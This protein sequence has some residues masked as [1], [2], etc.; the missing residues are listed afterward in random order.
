MSTPGF[1]LL[2]KTD[3]PART[4]KTQNA[5]DLDKFIF[6]GLHHCIRIGTASDRYS[7]WGGQIYTPEK[8]VGRITKRSNNVGGKRYTEEI[9]PVDSVTEYF[10]HFDILEIDFTFYR[11]LLDKDLKPTSNYKILQAYNKYLNDS[12]RLILKVPQVIFARKLFKTGKHIDN[13]N[14]LNAEMFINQFYDPANA[15]LGDNLAGFIF[16]QEYQRK[17]DRVPP[18]KYVKDLDKFIGSLPKD[19]RYH[20]ETRTEFYLTKP[21]FE[22]LKKYGVGQ[23]L[24]H[25]AWLPRLLKQFAYAG[26]TFTNPESSIVRLITPIGMR[27][28]EAYALAFPFDM[29]IRGMMQDEM[30][31][32]TVSLMKTAVEKAITINVIINNRAG[33]SAPMLAREIVNNFMS[34]H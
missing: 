18:Q 13:P 17:S 30:I 14:Y 21:Y 19:T 20:F 32:E 29:M 3:K 5:V 26:N 34:S 4:M 15:I 33:G 23:V 27:Y 16:E 2:N 1:S 7:G 25:W 28:E 24:S 10:Q 8:Y 6:R 9:L 22:V 12:D 11:P 31:A